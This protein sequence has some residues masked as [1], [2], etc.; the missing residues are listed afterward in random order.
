MAL[1][2]TATP[3][4]YSQFRD[5]VLRGDLPVCKEIA[6]QMRLID[7]LIANPL[8]Y[9]DDKAVDGFIE[10]CEK[11]CTLVDGG[12]VNMLDTFKLGAEDLLG[13]YYFIERSVFVPNENGP[14]G[15]Y[16]LRQIKMRLRNK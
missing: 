16:E 10:Y 9:Y 12:P 4:Y 11:E 8:Y 3:Y 2:N 14:G 5:A 13:W 6:Q 1:S 15:H 7:D